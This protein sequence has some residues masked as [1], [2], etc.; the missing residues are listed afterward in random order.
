MNLRARCTGTLHLPLTVER[1][2]SFFTPEGERSWAGAGWDPQYPVQPEP[3]DATGVG[4]V[5]RTASEGGDATWIVVA[6]QSAGYT[7][8]RVVPGRLA[9][10][11]EV[12]CRSLAERD[13]CQVS[14]TY[15][16]TSLGPEGATFVR[17]F[18][19]GYRRFLDGWR[20]KILARLGADD[21]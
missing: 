19:A 9:G 12:T 16:V 2:L 15:D 11:V 7:Y 5:F 13:E 18:E 1:A 20:T 4:T 17:E 21:A 14:V 10:T 8:A 3:P 6:S